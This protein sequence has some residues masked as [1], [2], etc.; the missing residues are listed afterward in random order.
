V[1][2]DNDFPDGAIAYR[3]Y[4][5]P[6]PDGTTASLAFTLGD[7]TIDSVP[8]NFARE[9]GALAYGL[10]SVIDVPEAPQFPLVWTQNQTQLALAVADEDNDLSDSLK[11][12]IARYIAIFFAD[13][14]PIAPQL[15]ALQLKMPPPANDHTLN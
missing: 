9:H 8:A 12:V 3:E 7:I 1:N 4:E 2:D 13:I 10:V 6:M 14:A 5:V 11:Q 15:A